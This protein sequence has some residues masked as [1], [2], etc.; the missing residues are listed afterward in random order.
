MIGLLQIYYGNARYK[1]LKKAFYVF[2]LI[3]FFAALH[4]AVCV[5]KY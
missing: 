1:G 4:T 3:S 2:V 5:R